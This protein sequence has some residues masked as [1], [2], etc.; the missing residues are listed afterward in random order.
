MPASA[1]LVYLF[2]TLQSTST[3]LSEFDKEAR[4]PREPEG[5]KEAY[6]RYLHIWKV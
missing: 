5:D 6:Y 1:R 3:T 2:H 4:W